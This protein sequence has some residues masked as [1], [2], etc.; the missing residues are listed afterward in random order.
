MTVKICGKWMFIPPQNGAI[1]YAPPDVFRPFT[2]ALSR[3]VAEVAV[4]DMA[5]SVKALAAAEH[6]ATE[7]RRCGTGQ[8]RR[9]FG[10]GGP[11]GGGWVK[12]YG[13]PKIGY[14]GKW[15]HGLKPTSPLV[16]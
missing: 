9:G 2:R 14:P 13:N 8:E 6:R 3:R 5:S 12:K 10:A 4:L 11:G 1:G 16:V 7:Q 15:K